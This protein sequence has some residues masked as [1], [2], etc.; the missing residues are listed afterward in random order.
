[1]LPETSWDSMPLW[2][3]A[4]APAEIA[5]ADEYLLEWGDIA[6]RTGKEE[7]DMDNDDGTFLC[8][9]STA[10]MSTS[11][12]SMSLL[13]GFRSS[14]SGLSTW[15]DYDCDT[16]MPQQETPAG[17]FETAFQAAGKPA[18]QLFS[19]ARGED[20]A[21]T[22]GVSGFGRAEFS[23][24]FPG[25]PVNRDHRA[26]TTSSC[27]SGSSL[28]EQRMHS[29]SDVSVAPAVS[30]GS[31]NCVGDLSGGKA[32]GTGASRGAAVPSPG[33]AS[34]ATTFGPLGSS[35]EG[36]PG[37]Q[38]WEWWSVKRESRGWRRS[39]AGETIGFGWLRQVRG[40]GTG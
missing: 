39:A 11:P 15:E 34:A 18:S 14:S 24:K 40:A 33:A 1:M 7:N 4:P 28:E 8:P 32:G 2:N 17:L 10:D 5:A 29:R 23:E 22:G 6:H 9:S 25:M 20:A 38:S 36:G 12:S 27:S 31:I 3:L 19:P 30:D 35:K 21:T 26:D 37:D 13:S 16:G